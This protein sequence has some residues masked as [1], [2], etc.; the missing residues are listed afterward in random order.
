LRSLQPQ[1]DTDSGPSESP[2]VSFPDGVKVLH[3]C[4]DAM[5]DICFVHG[6]TRNRESTW[7]ARG[8][9]PPWPKN[10]LPQELKEARILTYGYDAY[11]VRRSVASSARLIDHA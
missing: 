4:T 1:P 9:S 11:V 7:T 2:Q 5:V 3:E 10:L 8:Q 6:L